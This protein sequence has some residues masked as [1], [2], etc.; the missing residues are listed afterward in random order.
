MKFEE[1]KSETGWAFHQLPAGSS[2]KL[3]ARHASTAICGFGNSEQEAAQDLVNKQFDA[4]ATNVGVI[5][6]A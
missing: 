5:G 6:H 4:A 2:W 3:M 1:I